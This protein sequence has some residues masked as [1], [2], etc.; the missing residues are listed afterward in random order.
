MTEDERN[1]LYMT[2]PQAKTLNGLVQSFMLFGLHT[3][4]GMDQSYP[5]DAE[6]D[7]LYG[8]CDSDEI[9]EESEDGKK[10]LA[11]GWHYD[12]DAGRWA[13]YT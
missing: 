9:P 11:L 2:N 13:Y 12:D 8:P 5:I 4:K 10:L 1:A 7:I 6:H 3:E